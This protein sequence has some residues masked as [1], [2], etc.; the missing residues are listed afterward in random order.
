MI[1]V[2]V[3]DLLAERSVEHR[4]TTVLPGGDNFAQGS[5]YEWGDHVR[6][7]SSERQAG[8]RNDFTFPLLNT[9]QT[10]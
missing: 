8:A 1:Y 6:G 10:L 2:C 9:L 3:L 5:E 7:G 4:P